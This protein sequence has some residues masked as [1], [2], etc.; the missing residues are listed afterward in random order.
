MQI[1]TLDTDIFGRSKHQQ[2]SLELSNLDAESHLVYTSQHSSASA[3]WLISHHGDIAPLS[4]HHGVIDT[5]PQQNQHLDQPFGRFELSTTVLLSLMLHGSF[6]Q[7][8]SLRHDIG[9][10][11]WSN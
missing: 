8:Q 5:W 2:D 6:H 3:T 10:T 11:G 4:G 1:H 7:Q 9:A